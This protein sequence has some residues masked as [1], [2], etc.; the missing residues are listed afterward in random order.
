AGER[1]TMLE[2]AVEILHRLM[3]ETSVTFDGRYYQLR[4][5]TITPRPVQRPR[6]PVLIAGHRPR[7]IRLA[8][9]FADQW[10]TF[11]A[12]AGSATDGLQD[13]LEARVRALDEACVSIGRDS[14]EI[15]RST[16]T[17]GEV[18]GSE[19]AYVDFVE[20]HRAMGFT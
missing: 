16:W 14:A 2:E 11:P 6:I 8:A 19:D 3:N 5:A 10:D 4:E 18:L 12:I 20:R 1:V 17:G 7:M 13:E 9:R 15:R